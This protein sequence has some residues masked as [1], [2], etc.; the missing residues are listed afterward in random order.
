MRCVVVGRGGKLSERRRR[1]CRRFNAFVSSSQ[2]V[3]Q[4]R[5]INQLTPIGQ[6]ERLRDLGTL[7]AR[8]LRL[9]G[10]P[11][12][13]GEPAG[14]ATHINKK[15]ERAVVALCV[16]P[17]IVRVNGWRSCGGLW[18]QRRC[19]PVA[20]LRRRG[21]GARQPPPFQPKPP[22]KQ[23]FFFSFFFFMGKKVT[24]TIYIVLKK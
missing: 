23:L 1:L 2:L 6:L 14:Y 11:W 16:P 13:V 17:S 10:R 9:I 21:E 3:S 18:E 24:Y 4:R 8:A 19:G 5:P 20:K 7:A 12:L 22:P 15:T